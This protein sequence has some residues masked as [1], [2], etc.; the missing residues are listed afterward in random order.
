[1]KGQPNRKDERPHK[2]DKSEEDAE[3]E[4]NDDE[5]EPKGEEERDRQWPK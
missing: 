3:I 1:M 5:Q 4:G 2:S